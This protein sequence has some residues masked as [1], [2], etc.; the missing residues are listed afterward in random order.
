MHD[1]A[2]LH[3]TG[4]SKHKQTLIKLF[5]DIKNMAI[6]QYL[7]FI[8]SFMM[9]YKTYA[10]KMWYRID[11]KDTYKCIGGNYAQNEEHTCIL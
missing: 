1:S 10:P 6:Q 7:R 2:I 5:Y 8:L 9:N 4:T 3:D 11:Y